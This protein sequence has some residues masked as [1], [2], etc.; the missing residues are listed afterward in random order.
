MELAKRLEPPDPL[1][2]VRER[3][4][5]G[6]RLEAG[7]EIGALL[8]DLDA[9]LP[10]STHRL[11]TRAERSVDL[12]HLTMTDQRWTLTD[13]GFLFCDGIAA[14]LMAEAESPH[15]AHSSP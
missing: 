10:G 5:M 8:S 1:R 4:M 7:L 12:G 3:I 9:L 15:P 11:R 13:A 2:L 6:L 14:Q